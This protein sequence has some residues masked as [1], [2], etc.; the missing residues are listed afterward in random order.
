[1]FEDAAQATR[2]PGRPRRVT[3]EAVIDAACAFGIDQIEMG[4]IAERLGVGVGTLYRYVRDREHLIELVAA[5]RSRREGVVDRGQSWQ[6]VLRESA[7]SAFEVFT[8]TPE[9]ITHVMAASIAD[10]TDPQTTERLLKLLVDRGF[11]P[12]DALNLYQQVHQLVAGAVVGH[13]FKRALE[14]KFGGYGGLVR[15]VAGILGPD[16]TPMLCGAIEA[17]GEPPTIGDYRPTLE[18]ILA[19][20]ERRQRAKSE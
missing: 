1:M 13:V 17:G 14:A 16:Q 5:R 10:E 9:L 20:Y 6:D 8:R 3:L 19:E 15:H 18:L 12:V 2:R 4:P 7:A 11:D